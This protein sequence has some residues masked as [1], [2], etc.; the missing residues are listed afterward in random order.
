MIKV[1]DYKKEYQIEKEEILA[2]VEA[3]FESGVLVF[4]PHLEEFEKKFANYCDCK[5]GVGVGNCTDALEIALK[6]LKIGNGD[7]VITVSNTA[8][9]TVSAIVSAGA[10]PVFVDVDEYHLMDV[11]KIED[12]VTEKTKCILP[13]HLYGQSV[14]M[15]SVAKLAQKYNLKIVEDC[16]QAHGATYKGKKVGSMSDAGAFSFYPTKVL[17]AYGDGGM[18]TTNSE[19]LGDTL[20]RLRFYG[21]EKKKMSSGHWNG[22]YYSLEHGI[23]SRLDELHAAILLKKLNHLDEYI[24]ARCQIAKRYDNELSC[25]S[26]ILPRE[27]R[28]NK[29]VYYVYVVKHSK[30]DLFIENLRERDIHVN[31]SYPWPIHTMVGYEYLG[32]KDGDLPVTERYANEIFSLPMYPTLTNDEQTKI[33]NEVKEIDKLLA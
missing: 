20:Q 25:T 12:L 13:V 18:I 30:R 23:N 2:A 28:E 32:W 24:L 19:E 3:V 8:V 7:E 27:R 22:K 16:A 17:G 26:M 9:P 29:Y 4:G 10:I 15:D 11:S 1:W 5:Y 31:I 6:G 33:I 14:D 21:M